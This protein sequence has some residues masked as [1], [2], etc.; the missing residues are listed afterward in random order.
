MLSGEDGLE[1]TRQL[2]R[3]AI[4]HLNPQGILVVEVGNSAI[5]LEKEFT[6]VPFI[7]PSVGEGDS[8]VF[9][10]S[11]EVLYENSHFFS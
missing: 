10:L 2:L 5:A 1:F 4:D 9:I 11:H 3:E 8:G 7:W 6:D